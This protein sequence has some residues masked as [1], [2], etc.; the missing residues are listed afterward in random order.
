M[1]EK[2]IAYGQTVEMVQIFQVQNEK[3]MHTISWDTFLQSTFALGFE[4]GFHKQFVGHGAKRTSNVN[5]EEVILFHK[6]KGLIIY[7]ETFGGRNMGRAVIY[8]EV[9]G[10]LR[11][12]ENLTKYFSK[13]KTG[14]GI[15]AFAMRVSKNFQKFGQILEKMFQNFT[16][17]ENWEIG[18]ETNFLNYE[19]REHH[20][21]NT[22]ITEQKIQESCPEVRRIIYGN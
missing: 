3:N 9:K 2:Q 11:G 19:E 1:S 22:Q 6:E 15:I 16:F 12:K 14:D 18:F 20:Q 17:V 7:A 10:K 21:S 4:L 5:E 13:M 8:G